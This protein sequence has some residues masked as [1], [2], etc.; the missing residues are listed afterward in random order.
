[1]HQLLPVNSDHGGQAPQLDFIR[2]QE[3]VRAV[4]GQIAR[5]EYVRVQGSLS[6]SQQLLQ[7]AERQNAHRKP[8]AGQSWAAQGLY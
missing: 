5:L 4:A 7:N 3:M 6:V 2:A 8:L 1:M